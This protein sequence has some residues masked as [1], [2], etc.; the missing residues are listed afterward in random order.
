VTARDPMLQETADGTLADHPRHP[1]YAMMLV[2]VYS[3]TVKRADRF[4]SNW[5]A[6]ESPSVERE[7]LID[8][9]AFADNMIAE[10]EA[11]VGAKKRRP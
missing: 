10:S 6:F 9:E 1:K 5:Y 8:F 7:F 2:S 3:G 11:K 4:M